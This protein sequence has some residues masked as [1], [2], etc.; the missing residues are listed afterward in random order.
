MPTLRSMSGGPDIAVNRPLVIVGRHARCDARL[1]SS[2]VSRRH[3]VLTEASGDVVIRDLGSTNGTW[4]NGR[5][6]Q[7]ERLK[8]GDEVSIA[9]ICFR[10]EPTPACHASAA[11]SSECSSL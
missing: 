4:V 2:R 3:C 9:H 10:L 7:R 6:V 5:R 1:E 11:K 8:P